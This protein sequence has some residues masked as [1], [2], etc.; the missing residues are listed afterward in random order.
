[1]RD[2][3]LAVI[4]FGS[5]P[6]ILSRPWIGILM[7]SWVGYMNPHRMAYGFAFDMQFAAVLAVATLVGLLFDRGK[8]SIPINAITVIWVLFI[9]HVSITTI[10]A[11]YPTE[12]ILQWKQVIKIQLM[13]FVTIMLMRS[14]ERITALVWV[15]VISI[16]FFGVKGGIFSLSTGFNYVVWG[17]RGGMIEG[18]NELALALIMIVP[19]LR[20][21]QLD[22]TNKWVRYGLMA[23]MALSVMSIIASYSRGAFV[24]C[25]V[26]GMALAMQSKYKIR[27]IAILLVI[28][29]VGLSFVPQQWSDRMGTIQTYEEDGSAMGRINSWYFAVEL[30]KEN[31]VVG[32]G[33]GSF[34]PELFERLAPDPEDFHDSHSI[35]FGI[36]GNQG[37]VGLGLFL[38][39][40]LMTLIANGRLRRTTKN[41]PEFEWVY[42][43]ASMVRVS[44]IGY[45]TGGLFLGLQYFD[46]YYHLVAITVILQLIVQR[47]MRNREPTTDVSN[48][49]RLV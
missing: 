6:L 33:F 15:I 11:I 32:G 40:G 16:G 4:I 44:L 41:I 42:N 21:L 18:N 10:M 31:P 27:V 37:F 26:M 46:L 28:G 14:R 19:L 39:L 38:L 34:T 30:A 22:A 9:I 24:A 23:S 2:I 29:I 25:T 5:V 48:N 3:A 13:C 20:F 35:Y 1:M 7:F 12:A 36:L 8:K 43:L 47:D 45:A 49:V 17:P